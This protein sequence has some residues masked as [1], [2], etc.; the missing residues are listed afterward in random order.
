MDN[1]LDRFAKNGALWLFLVIVLIGTFTLFLTGSHKGDVF[2]K[3]NQI[4]QP[5]LNVF[6]LKGKPIGS[7]DVEGNVY[8]SI[9]RPIGFVD[10]NGVVYN[11]SKASIGQIDP[12]G[13]VLNRLGRVIGMADPE[14]N[15]FVINGKK[16]G[17]VESPEAGNIDLIGGA[18]FLL[19]LKTH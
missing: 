17:S 12:D 16:V 10:E 13:K 4:D 6:N 5:E 11:I 15:V 19:L 9:G 3:E 7:V 2:A 18:A 8:N 14:G 1:F